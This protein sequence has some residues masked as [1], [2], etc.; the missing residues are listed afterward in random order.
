MSTDSPLLRYPHRMTPI[1]G[2]GVEPPDPAPFARSDGSGSRWRPATGR[3]ASCASSS[4]RST[5]ATPG[6]SCARWASCDQAL[7]PHGTRRDRLARRS[8]R[9]LRRLKKLAARLSRAPSTAR[10]WLRAGWRN[11]PR[12]EPAT[13]QNYAVICLPMIEW[14]FRCQRPQHLMRRFARSS[15]LVLYAA[16]RFH[17]GTAARTRPIETNVLEVMLPGDPAA[18]V[19]HDT[20]REDD[21][22]R[23]LAAMERLAS[24][25]GLSRAVGRRP[26]PVLDPAGRGVARAVR[27]ADRLRLHG[28][29][30]RLL[31]HRR[32]GASRSSAG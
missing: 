7:A 25:R 2:P 24:E 4:A 14:H 23:M 11:R 31:G 12:V 26:A 17:G 18:N 8:L 9:G 13:S 32:R 21:R 28:R 1:M 19:Y 16:N 15:H 10:E 5:P 22:A 20:L 29:P 3:S 27:L 30:F 6:R